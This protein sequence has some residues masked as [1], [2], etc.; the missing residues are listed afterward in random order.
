MVAN[1][2]IHLDNPFQFASEVTTSIPCA[3]GCSVELPAISQRVLY[4]RVEY[5]DNANRV[6]QLGPT[7]VAAVP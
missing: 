7:Q 5:R 1:A 6:I 4:Y 2:T 3:A